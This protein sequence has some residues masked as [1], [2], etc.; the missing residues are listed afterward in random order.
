MIEY[1]FADILIS[2]VLAL[3]MF[4]IGLSLTFQ[5][6][7]N[8]FLFPKAIITGLSSQMLVL[9]II[10]FLFA[11]YSD[12][13]P[14]L[15]VGLI[16]LSVCPG[17]TTSN[18]ITYLL[19]GNTALS[20]SMTTI[21][22]FLTLFSIP[23]IVNIGLLYFLGENTEFH[24]P[25][26][27]TIL[28]IFY[29]TIIP[30]SIGVFIKSRLPVIANRLNYQIRIPLGML[31]T[32]KFNV[33]KSITIILLGIVFAIKL[34]ASEGSGGTDLTRNDF[35]QLLPIGLLF[36]ATGLLFGYFVSVAM[37]LKDRIPMTIGIEVGLQNTTL[38]FLV[39]GTL[40][41]NSEMQKPA[42]VYAFF[43]FWTAIIFGLIT[44]RLQHEKI[45]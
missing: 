39:A 42:L 29:I 31:K 22:S 20:V 1:N 38:A 25:F 43:S 27:E 40:L 18:F 15:K 26:L 6:F 13:Q 23:F 45:A 41:Q 2:G 19:N 44:K 3:I 14:E 5:N 21:N 10:A 33:I 17:G 12:L 16:I 30:A 36:N 7:K 4:G 37:N 11:I 9:P 28:Q 24:L 34:F 32:M 8:I 35:M